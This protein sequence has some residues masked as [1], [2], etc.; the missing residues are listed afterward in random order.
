MQTDASYLK[1]GFGTLVCKAISKKLGQMDMDVYACVLPA[2][3][4][5]ILTFE[6]IGFKVV[7][8]CHWLQTFPTKPFE[9]V[10]D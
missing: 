1:Q 8:H 10:D 2:N 3:T 7:D 6:K 9:L 4:P 5:S